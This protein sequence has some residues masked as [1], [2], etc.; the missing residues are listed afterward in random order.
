[1]WNISTHYQSHPGSCHHSKRLS[2]KKQSQRYD[3]APEQYELQ[4]AT[5]YKFTLKRREFFKILGSGIAIT[6][7]ASN[8]A[9]GALT[10]QAGLPEDQISAWL[11]IGENG[12]VTIYTG[13]AEVGQ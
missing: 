2:M 12:D 5:P 4:E 6:F 8:N 1:M 11:Y 3:F 9:A 10:G 13:K 7:A